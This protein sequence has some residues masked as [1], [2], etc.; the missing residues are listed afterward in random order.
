[1]EPMMEALRRFANQSSKLPS[2][3]K[4]Y[5]FLLVLSLSVMCAG[6]VS[7]Q[8]CFPPP[9]GMVS[10]WTGDGN[11]NDVVGSNNGTLQGGATFAPGKVGQAFSFNGVDAYVDVPNSN[12]LNPGTSDFTV[13]FW[14]NTSSVPNLAEYLLTKRDVCNFTSF[15]SI[16]TQSTGTVTAELDDGSFTNYNAIFGTAVVNDG[17]WHHIALVR[18]SVTATLY[19]DGFSNASGS[20]PGITN[21]SNSSDLLFANSPCVPGNGSQFYQGLIDE[22]EY[23]NRALSP[24]EIAGIIAAGSAGKCKPG[25]TRAAYVANAR[26]NSVSV[27]DPAT[28]TVVAAVPVGANPVYTAVT[29]DGTKAYVADA[30]ANSVS[31]IDTMSNTVEATVPVGSTPVA[32]AITPDG[33]QAY[34]ANAGA[35]SVSVIAIATNTLAKTIQVGNNPVDIAVTPDG[36]K[37]Y[38][39]NAGAG[40]VSVIATATDTV[41]ATVS[42]GNLPVDVVITPDGAHAYVANAFSN[43]VSVIDTTTNAVTTVHVGR[44]PVSIAITPDGTKAY[45]TNA[46]ANSVSVITTATNT[47]AKTIPVGTNPGDIAVTPDGTKAYITNVGSHSVSVIDT[48]TNSVMTTVQVGTNPGDIAVTTNGNEAYVTNS[49]ANSV[50]V[51]GTA[52]NTVAATVAVGTS[53]VNAALH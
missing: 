29:P 48:G 47:V 50:S 10:W 26:S 8:L 13:D 6:M 53:P 49:G 27:I 18:Q 52:S 39:T 20:T 45:V 2:S 24:V 5:S 11:P 35:N 51:I 17:Q 30:S 7:A 15:W 9:S 37:A 4:N 19:I 33:T 43:S 38:V 28:H 12:N 40:S 41:A 32:V 25:T 34:V 22:V 14:M 46:R 31:V 36:S 23:F 21:I 44:N 1:M 42:V 3:L 16:Q